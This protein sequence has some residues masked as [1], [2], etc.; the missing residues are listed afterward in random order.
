MTIMKELLLATATCLA[1][2][3]MANACG[4][5]TTTNRVCYSR[6]YDLTHLAKHP[7]QGV[8]AMRIALSPLEPPYDFDLDVQFREDKDK[9]SWNVS[10]ICQDYGPGFNCGIINDGCE[11]IGDGRHFYITKNQ[12]AVYLY[13]REIQLN[14]ETKV[15]KWGDERVLTKGK[16][17]KVF[18]L[19]KTVCWKEEK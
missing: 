4:G 10:G 1:F 9:W 12:K 5:T 7:Y 16:D 13:P 14:G 8:A 6:S 11:P 2:V 15:G 17:D 3:G 19:D 18:R